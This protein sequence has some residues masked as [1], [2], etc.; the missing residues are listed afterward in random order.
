MAEGENPFL[1][2]PPPGLLPPART[3]PG[4]DAPPAGQE[5]VG[6][7]SATRRI[8]PPR[9]PVVIRPPAGGGIPFVTPTATPAVTPPGAPSAAVTA[10]PLTAVPAPAPPAAAP[11]SAAPSVVDDDETRIVEPR[12]SRVPVWRLVLPDGSAVTV[13]GAVFVGRNPTRTTGDVE[14]QLLPV[15]DTTKSV[16]K[17]HALIE[18]LDGGLWVTDLNSTNGVF[19]TSE[20][21]DDVQPVPGE[22]T[23]VPAGCDI[24]LGE[25]VIQVEQA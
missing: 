22:R 19:V 8:S 6:G 12:A 7:D 10:V 16:S 9:E 20:F 3:Q 21:T 15:D 1:I 4:D 25:F 14:G 5:T 17:T 18:V 11:A 2:V 13:E 24:E 23:P